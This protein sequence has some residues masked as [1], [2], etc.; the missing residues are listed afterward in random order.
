MSI[1]IW[2]C[3]FLSEHV[4]FYLNMSISIWSLLWYT[5]V[6]W[7]L[8][9]ELGIKQ[10]KD[11]LDNTDLQTL[12]YGLLYIITDGCALVHTEG[13]APSLPLLLFDFCRRIRR[14][15][16]YI[17]GFFNLPIAV[18]MAFVLLINVRRNTDLW[19][20]VCLRVTSHNVCLHVTSP[21]VCLHVTSLNVC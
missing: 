3:L 21:N 7:A 9:L 2:T 14:I 13:R 5:N 17:R 1:S 8:N 12:E 10:C 15:N 18:F 16:R 4:Y 6:E 19:P 20:H 11:L